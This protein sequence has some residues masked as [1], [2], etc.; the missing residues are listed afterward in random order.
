M[1][2]NLRTIMRM[3]YSRRIGKA[4]DF[5]RIG[6]RRMRAIARGIDYIGNAGGR[7]AYFDY[8]CGMNPLGKMFGALKAEV[9]FRFYREYRFKRYVRRHLQRYY[10]PQ[11]PRAA[12]GRK[13]IVAM[14]DGRRAHGGLADRLRSMATVYAYCREHG[15]DFRIHFTSPFRLEEYLLPN[16]YDWRIAPEEISYNSRDARAVYI[17]PARDHA[18]RDKIFQRRIAH[19]FFSQPYRQI[20]VYTNMYY[21]EARFGEL[22]H[23][24]FRPTAALQRIVDEQEAMLRQDGKEFVAVSTRFCELLGD[25]REHADRPPQ[26]LAPQRQE[27]L[28][29]RCCRCIEAIR[30]AHPEAGAVLVTSDSRKFLDRAAQLAGVKV[31]PGRIGHLDVEDGDAAEVH[32]KTL[33]DFLVLARAAKLYLLVAGG[34]YRGNFARRAAQ[35]GGRPYEEVIF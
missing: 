8:L 23:E 21:E 34:M 20:H 24:L 7:L 27:E 32:R 31:L 35:A 28:M 2:S 12:N 18:E 9:D 22:F 15:L 16:R 6:L 1:H 29:E 4:V 5:C 10:T 25:F 30:N 11:A 26:A 17:D 3:I 33:S 19:K 13:T 14:F